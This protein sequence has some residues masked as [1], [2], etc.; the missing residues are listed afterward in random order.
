MNSLTISG[1]ELKV[2]DVVAVAKASAADGGR[3]V[4]LDLAALPKIKAARAVVDRFVAEGRVV[5]GITTGFGRFKD[6]IISADQVK[7]LQ[8][9]LVR[10]HAVGVGPELSEEVVRAMLLVRANTL[11]LGHSGVRPIVIQTLLDM[12]NAG[13]HPCI[14]SQGSL[15][16]SGGIELVLSINALRDN[17]VPPTINLD[18][19][20]PNCD[21][22][23][24]PLQPRERQI[25]V[26]MSNSFGFGGHNASIV[27]GDLRNGVA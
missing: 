24:T 10:S 25:K 12:L 7:Q 9:N 6:K 2:D 22:D 23:Y 27:V 11:A 26:A 20:D 18:N 3:L 17:V 13:V 8:V 14:P 21:L 5:Y 16:A 4:A 1:T 15:G 19:P